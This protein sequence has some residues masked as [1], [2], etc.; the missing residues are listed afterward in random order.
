MGYISKQ[1][2]IWCFVGMGNDEAE[3]KINRNLILRR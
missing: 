1:Y 2:Q 3:K